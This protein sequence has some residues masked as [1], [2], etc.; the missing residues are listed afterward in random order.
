[1]SLTLGSRESIAISSTDVPTEQLLLKELE[2]V[3]DD[4]KVFGVS[5]GVPPSKLDAIQLGN[6]QG[7]VNNWKLKMFQFWLQSQRD[8]PSWKDVV[9]ALEENKRFYLAATLSRKYL[10]AADHDS[11]EDKGMSNSLILV[12][13]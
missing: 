10:L 8:D 12:T 2:D 5:L 7:G 3:V 9:R 6:A 1:M 13:V 11:S 4:W